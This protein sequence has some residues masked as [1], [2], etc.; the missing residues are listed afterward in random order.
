MLVVLITPTAGRQNEFID[1]QQAK[2]HIAVLPIMDVIT[3]WN[4]TMDL[5]ESASRLQS[6]TRGW[7]KN[8]KYTYFQ[9]LFATQDEWTIVQY[10]MEVL[11]P[12]LYCTLCMSKR[13][14]VTPL[15]VLTVYNDILDHLDGIMQALAK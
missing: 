1:C 5:L 9:P 3:W 14:S 10:V 13:H 2:V 15:H 12:F 11:W 4:S 6:F 7:L 8:P